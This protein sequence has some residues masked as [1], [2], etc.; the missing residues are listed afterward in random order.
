MQLAAR[1]DPLNKHVPYKRD[2]E[3]NLTSQDFTKKHLL[4]IAKANKE[5]DEKDAEAM[6]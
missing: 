6:I 1:S 2:E 5:N 3:S 4:K